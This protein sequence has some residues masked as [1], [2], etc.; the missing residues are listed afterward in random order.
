MA[1]T[2]TLPDVPE[3]DEPFDDPFVEPLDCGP[4]GEPSAGE[5]EFGSWIAELPVDESWFWPTA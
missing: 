1:S 2:S 4:F 3:L 5:F